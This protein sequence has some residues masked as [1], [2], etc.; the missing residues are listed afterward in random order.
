MPQPAGK[1][2]FT[3]DAFTGFDFFLQLLPRPLFLRII[4]IKVLRF[5][6]LIPSSQ[7]VLRAF[8][9]APKELPDGENTF[10]VGLGGR[11]SI[12]N[13]RGKVKPT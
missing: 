9:N 6:G 1:R 5:Y 13:T 7:S 12:V 8:F 3:I 10:S 4:A 2:H 11:F